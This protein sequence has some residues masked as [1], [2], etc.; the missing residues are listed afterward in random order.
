METEQTSKT[1]YNL[2]LNKYNN[3]GFTVLSQVRNKPG[4]DNIRTADAIAISQSALRDTSFV[5]F[6][7]KVSRADFRTELANPRKADEIAKFCNKWYIVSPKGI[8]PVNEMPENWGLLETT[9]TQVW[10]TKKAP[11]LQ[12]VPP[13]RAF[14]AMIV[15]RLENRNAVD[16]AYWRGHRHGAETES[17]WRTDNQD[18]NRE[19]LKELQ[20]IV[21][22]FE[23][24]SGLRIHAC[25]KDEVKAIGE[26]VSLIENDYVID[27]VKRM[28]DTISQ[29]LLDVGGARKELEANPLRVKKDESKELVKR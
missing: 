27:R 18:R 2:I 10:I 13:S 6:E 21:S 22:I 14:V 7:I 8:V 12:C 3:M 29:L 5:G 9:K 24:K 23:E 16:K 15:R 19:E 17:K 20:E 4:Y 26:I 11:E 1:I 25:D 28:E